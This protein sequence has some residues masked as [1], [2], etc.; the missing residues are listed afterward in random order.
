M[1]YQLLGLTDD[2]ELARIL[3]FIDKFT[4][5][6]WVSADNI[7]S[8]W[9]PK[10]KP[11]ADE[12]R[13]FMSKVV[14]LGYAIDNDEAIDSGKYRIQILEK[15]GR[16]G[17][18]NIETVTEQAVQL[19]PPMVEN[20]KDKSGHSSHSN[21]STTPTTIGSESG[22]NF[23]PLQNGYSGDLDENIPTTD[24]RSIN[25][26]HSNDSGDS[27][28]TSTTFTDKNIFKIGDY[29]KAGDDI[30]VITEVKEDYISGLDK[31]KNAIGGHPNSFT[32]ASVEDFAAT[33]GEL[34][35]EWN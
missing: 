16:S 34:D 5:K 3:K 4:S 1:Q 10:P 17:R 30:V 21:G 2:P 35:D 11:N 13:K 12:L 18:K 22:R 15:S 7:R 29:A 23:K 26:I 24:G 28:T 27:P 25:N 14:T 20:K 6:G 32:I 9:S 31:D 19:R 33:Q 8:W